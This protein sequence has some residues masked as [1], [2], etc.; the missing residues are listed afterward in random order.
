MTGKSFSSRWIMTFAVF[1]S[2]GLFLL[3]CACSDNDSDAGREQRAFAFSFQKEEMPMPPLSPGWSIGALDSRGFLHFLGYA[4]D[5]SGQLDH[6]HLGYTRWNGEAWETEWIVSQP[7]FGSKLL[8]K[9]DDAERPHVAYLTP[10]ETEPESV[11]LRY[12]RKMDGIWHDSLVLRHYSFGDLDLALDEQ[13]RPHFAVYQDFQ[14]AQSTRMVYIHGAPD[15]W[16]VEEV[17]QAEDS[18]LFLSLQ[19]S[20]DLVRLIYVRTDHRDYDDDCADFNEVRYG[21][22]EQGVWRRE[23][24]DSGEENGQEPYLLLGRDDRILT[25]YSHYQNREDV[26]LKLAWPDDGEWSS[27]I[28]T[29]GPIGQYVALLDDHDITH[30]IYEMETS[31][32]RQ[33]WVLYYG[34]AMSG[35]LEVSLVDD[36]PG[37]LLQGFGVDDAGRVHVYYST[38]WHDPLADLEKQM[39]HG[40]IDLL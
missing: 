31:D 18:T 4:E 34:N 10:R 26:R 37:V 32:D 35:T 14:E 1:L 33:N 19:A 28:C 16:T 25:L 30:L 12:A 39:W 17:D 27:R 22:R 23:T 7:A 29:G 6:T 38:G 21:V 13:N 3:L 36:T 9:L 8:L 24:I 20:N 40:T 11:D 5:E 2:V 15:H